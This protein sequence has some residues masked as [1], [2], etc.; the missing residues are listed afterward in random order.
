[1]VNLKIYLITFERVH[2]F[3]SKRELHFKA[4]QNKILDQ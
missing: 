4:F 1:M 2:F 3:L